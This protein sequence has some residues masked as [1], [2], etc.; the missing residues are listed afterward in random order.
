MCIKQKNNKPKT[1]RISALFTPLA[2][3]VL[4][5]YSWVSI[6]GDFAW[7]QNFNYCTNCLPACMGLRTKTHFI[8]YASSLSQIIASYEHILIYNIV[9]KT[10]HSYIHNLATDENVTINDFL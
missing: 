2:L 6:F 8:I 9:F 3:S 1:W 7:S 4:M 10:N 5:L